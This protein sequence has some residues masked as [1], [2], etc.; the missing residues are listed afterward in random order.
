MSVKG[1][2]VTDVT[3]WSEQS[4]EIDCSGGHSGWISVSLEA[5]AGGQSL[6]TEN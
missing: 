3:V 5:G 1:K 6:S 2:V 4:S